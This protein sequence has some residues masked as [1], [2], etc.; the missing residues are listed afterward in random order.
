MIEKIKQIFKIRDLRKS[1][2][3]ILGMIVIFRI[4]AHIP[5]PGINLENLKEFFAS[6]QILGLINVFSGGSMENFSV[7]AMG[8]GPYITASIIFQLLVMI[9]PRLEAL[10]KEPGG[11]QKI[12]HWTRYLTVPLAALQG[13]AMVM[14]LR[15]QSSFKIIDSLSTFDLAVTI[16]T[17][18]AGTIF[19]M[20]IGELISERHIGNGISLLI[21]AGIVAN[22][23]GVLQKSLAVFDPAQIMNLVIFL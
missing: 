20:W 22:L 2:L 8:V 3:Y 15:Q 4:A 18:T 1:I 14:M 7:V 13:Y 9:V 5:V 11:Y 23:P 12:N 17:L 6:N 19:L 10:S 21:F 16:I